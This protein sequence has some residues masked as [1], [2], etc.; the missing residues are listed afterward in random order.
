MTGSVIVGSAVAGVI[1]CTP[2][3]GIANEIGSGSTPATPSRSILGSA[4]AQRIAARSEPRPLSSVFV[5][6]KLQIPAE[7]SEV[8]SGGGGLGLGA[9]MG[10]AVAVMTRPASMT[11]GKLGEVNV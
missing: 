8:S 7:Y 11:P 1:V 10:V 4:L 2:L 5:T 9:R 6:I 3:P